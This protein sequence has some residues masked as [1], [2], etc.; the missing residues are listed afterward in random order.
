M[1]EI[2]KASTVN[3]SILS[4]QSSAVTVREPSVSEVCAPSLPWKSTQEPL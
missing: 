3:K 1:G 4:D 2:K